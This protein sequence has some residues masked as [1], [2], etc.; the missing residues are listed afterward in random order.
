MNPV[1]TDIDEAEVAE[2]VEFQLS[3]SIRITVETQFHT[4]MIRESVGLG[5][6]RLVDIADPA[7]ICVHLRR[8]YGKE[9][10]TYFKRAKAGIGGSPHE[11]DAKAKAH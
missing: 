9:A 11:L 4:S 8:S 5:A 7:D 1:I 10:V 3:D 2:I 6:P